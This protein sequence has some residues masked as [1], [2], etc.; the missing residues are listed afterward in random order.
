MSDEITTQRK[1][2]E[3]SVIV[4]TTGTKEQIDRTIRWVVNQF[5]NSTQWAR[6]TCVAVNIFDADTGESLGLATVGEPASVEM[7]SQI[8]L[9]MREEEVA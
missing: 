4:E 3:V 2:L 8:D 7:K 5:R 1:H 6:G 9:M